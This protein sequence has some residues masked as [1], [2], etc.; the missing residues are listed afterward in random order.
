MKKIKIIA[1]L[2]AVCT[3]LSLFLSSCGK[4]ADFIHA[5]GRV[6][7]DGS[8]SVYLIKGMAFGNDVWSEPTEPPEWHHDENSYRELASLGF[9][10][11][12]FY[13]N[14]GLLE[15]APY[16]YRETGFAWLD[17]NIAWAKKNGIRLLLNMHCPQGGYQSQGD[18]DALWTVAENRERLKALWTEIAKRYA[19]EPTVLGY[20][21]V[22][23]PIPVGGAA[24][25]EALANEITDAVRAYDRNHII[26]VEK[27][28]GQKDAAGAEVSRDIPDDGW[29]PRISDGNAAYEF[30]FYDPFEFTHQDFDWVDTAGV[31]AV[32]PSDR[33]DRQTLEG[34][35][36]DVIAFSKQYDVPIFCGE[37]G[38]GRHCFEEGRGGEEWVSDMLDVLLENGVGF[39]YHDYKEYAFGLYY[40]EDG[41]P[42]Y[43]RNDALA[44][45]FAEKLK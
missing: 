39:S 1:A 16:E 40:D 8:G 36:A 44:D 15:Q 43:R 41:S 25:W 38:A 32:Y 42:E 2:A 17:R 33:A 27:I 20:G 28:S 3:V 19:D 30:H 24:A 31:N 22:N 11:V 6:L 9:N 34:L 12:R 35:L 5:D 7:K 18:G 21:L 26:F 37:F 29:F 13:L 45:V 23:E 4:T 10:T 14:Y